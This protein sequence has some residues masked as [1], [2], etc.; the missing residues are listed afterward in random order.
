MADIELYE[1][2]IPHYR[3]EHAPNRRYI[4]SDLTVS[5]MHKRF[6]ESG[7]DQVWYKLYNKV[8]KQMNISTTKLG[9]EQCD[10]CSEFELHRLN[11]TCANYT[12]VT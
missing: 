2:D 5:D 8:F 6:I 12:K 3:R 4:S 9:N 10:V 7:G 11:C 1:P